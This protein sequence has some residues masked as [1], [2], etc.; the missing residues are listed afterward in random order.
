MGWRIDTG[1][2]AFLLGG[3]VHVNAYALF[4]PDA[5]GESTGSWILGVGT[6][7]AAMLPIG[8]VELNATLRVA[9]G[10]LEFMRNPEL[11]EGSISEG[12]L[13][14]SVSAGIGFPM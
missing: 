8:D 6:Q 5:G 13:A 12:S 3:G 11:S 1:G 10:F 9:Y 7:A 4:P 2:V 14:W